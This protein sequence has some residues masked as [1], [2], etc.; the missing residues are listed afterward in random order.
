MVARRAMSN[1]HRVHNSVECCRLQAR[2]TEMHRAKDAAAAAEARVASANESLDSM[3]GS[4]TA[5]YQAARCGVGNKVNICNDM[6]TSLPLLLLL[7]G[8]Q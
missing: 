1:S 7:L 5:A 4:V 6:N 8:C 3:C 2:K